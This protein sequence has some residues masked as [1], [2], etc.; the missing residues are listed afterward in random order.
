MKYYFKRLWLFVFKRK[1]LTELTLP[2]PKLGY[3]FTG[4]VS[5]DDTEY[6]FEYIGMGIWY[7]KYCR[8]KPTVFQTICITKL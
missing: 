6:T 4:K 1:H 2:Y 8:V 5:L 3:T 7:S